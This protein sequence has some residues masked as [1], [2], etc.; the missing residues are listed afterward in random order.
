MVEEQQGDDGHR[1]KE[2]RQ[3]QDLIDGIFFGLAFIWGALVLAADLSGFKADLTWW[4]TGWRIFFFGIGIL[5]LLGAMIRLLLP[6]Y[7]RK[8][9]EGIVFGCIFLGIGL[10]DQGAWV[11]PVLLGI[12]GLTIL[13]GVLLQRR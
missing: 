8:I 9:G 5:A 11:W 10:G 7:R 2:K 4:T 6:E 12:V 1:G 13:R 3:Q